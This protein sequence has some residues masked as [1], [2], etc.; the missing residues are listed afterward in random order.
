MSSHDECRIERRPTGR[1]LEFA[2]YSGPMPE[3][4]AVTWPTAPGGVRRSA[5]DRPELLLF[6]PGRWLAPDPDAAM[7][8]LL[9]AAASAGA[10]SL[11]DVTGKWESLVVSGTG[12]GRL[13]ASALAVDAVLAGRGCAA[14]TLFD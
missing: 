6:A 13:L 12:A 4:I 8:A 3:F 9:E 2:A 14:V 7:V 10:G 1:G 11:I 5:A